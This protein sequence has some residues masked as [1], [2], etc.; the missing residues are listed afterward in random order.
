MSEEVDKYET[1]SYWEDEFDGYSV[2]AWEEVTREQ[3]IDRKA[4]PRTSGY[5]RKVLF[6][7]DK[8]TKNK[9]SGYFHQWINDENDVLHAVIEKDNGKIEQVYYTLVEFVDGF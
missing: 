5:G 2:S 3:F 7:E 9:V 8:Y 4:I 1:R 6:R